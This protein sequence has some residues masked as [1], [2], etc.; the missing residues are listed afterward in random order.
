MSG[1]RRDTLKAIMLAGAIF[2]VS[3]PAI[4]AAQARTYNIQA[5]SLSRALKAFGRASGH[6][7]LFQESQVRG[8]TAPSLKGSYSVDEALAR[9]LQGTGLKAERTPN[10]S[11]VIRQMAISAAQPQPAAQP[12]V[13]VVTDDAASDF[14][15]DIV[16][17]AQKREER[18]LETPQAVSVL[19]ARDLDRIG[20]TQLRDF[21]TVVPG[22]TF[23][24]AGAGLSQVTLRGVTVGF[25]AG[26]TTAIY[27]DEVPIGSATAFA[28]G[29]TITL[30]S[31][32][33][34]VER[35]EVLKG[36]QGTLYG[37]VSLGGLIKYVTPAPD[38]T[39]F[40]GK[41]QAGLSVTQ[42]GGINYRG[43]VAM[44]L[45]LV[46]DSLGLRASAFVTRDGGYVDN[47][48]LSRGNV[49]RSLGYG[50][51]VDL[52]ARPADRL[53][54]RLGA[55]LQNSAQD[56]YP[57]VNY[58]LAGQRAGDDLEQ[59]RVYDEPYDQEFR[60]ITGTIDL[61]LDFADLTSITNYQWI[62]VPRYVTDVS[63][64]FGPSFG[65]IAVSNTASTKKFTQEVRLASQGDQ[66]IEWLIGGFYTRE[67]SYQ[68]QIV[69]PRNVAGEPIANTFLNSRINSTFEELAGFGNLTWNVSDKFDVT[70]GIRFTRDELTFS[71][72]NSGTF[73]GP[74][75]APRTDRQST[76]T[77]LANARYHFSPNVVGYL[78]YA[79]G[80]RPGG[81]NYNNV[82][83]V[84]GQPIGPVM[85]EA[86]DL[87]SYEAGI[88]GQSD[89]RRFSIELAAFYQRWNNIIIAFQEQGFSGRSNAPDGASISGAELSLTTR[90]SDGLS[91]IGNLAYQD[92]KILGSV[93]SLGATKGERLPNVPTF[94]AALLA[95]YA[96]PVG[97]RT[98]SFG[99]TF[100][101]I[102]DRLSGFRNG[103]IPYY[104]APAY[105]TV[106]LRAEMTLAPVNL[107]L[108]LHNLFNA[109]GQVIS[110]LANLSPRLGPIPVAIIQPRTLGLTATVDF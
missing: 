81:P 12:Q 59:S 7:L 84:T 62:K 107:Q 61:D 51:R 3:T 41:A 19:S 88:K 57:F 90:P 43:G 83:P 101:Y 23:T 47:V 22:L 95:D 44:N 92:A 27:M 79:S 77:Y 110:P 45:P 105:A 75:T 54:I 49:N 74:S 8:K 66:P 76:T 37:A 35:I 38:P 80:F 5:S 48:A 73:L 87:H 64:L 13:A 17:T 78:R 89:D 103:T 39:R 108:F 32:L 68:T 102:G 33:F 9:L 28:R 104:T 40:G 1:K 71:Q 18:L 4:A 52:L 72:V 11:I 50:A 100:R 29:N 93:P 58:T 15:E 42:D 94:T 91:L 31:A 2:A 10:G 34:D 53:S 85:Y 16:V 97:D 14:A 26:A 98:A 60:L 36:P 55:M 99:A 69:L 67:R 6:H 30:D 96:L 25:D 46:E 86:D 56:G 63:A 109:R 82:N 20:A 21:A 24:S 70:A 65:A 106:D